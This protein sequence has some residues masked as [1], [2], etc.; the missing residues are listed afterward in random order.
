MIELFA[1][2]KS[3]MREIALYG[4]FGMTSAGIDTLSF[5]ILSKSVLPVL[6]ANFI[7][8]NIGITV[9]F[10]LN[11]FFNF[12][13]NT[14]LG[15]RAVTFFTIGYIGL[16]LSTLIMHVGVNG[17]AQSKLVIKIISVFFVAVVQ[18]LLNKLITFRN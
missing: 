12:R 14:N 15:K 16:A 1:K 2:Y 6:A 11:T 18:Y 7:S 3:W 10:F 8:V 9:S 4:I 17:L 13:K 5:C